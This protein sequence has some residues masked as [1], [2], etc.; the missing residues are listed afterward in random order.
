MWFLFQHEVILTFSFSYAKLQ[1]TISLCQMAWI[2][3]NF[4]LY[5]SP[6]GCN[7]LGAWKAE[8]GNHQPLAKYLRRYKALPTSTCPIHGLFGGCTSHSLMLPTFN[9]AYYQLSNNGQSCQQEEGSAMI[10]TTF[11]LV[12]RCFPHTCNK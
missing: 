8:Q 6:G 4:V 2:L 5:L 7:Q 11:L 1:N 9:W 12:W 3:E 10:D